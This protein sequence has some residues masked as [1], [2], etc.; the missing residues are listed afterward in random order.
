MFREYSLKLSSQIQELKKEFEKVR[1]ESQDNFALSEAERENRRLK[2][3]EIYERL[4]AAKQ[5]R[6]SHDGEKTS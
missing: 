6:D 4:L 3:K 5:N 2:A 1:D